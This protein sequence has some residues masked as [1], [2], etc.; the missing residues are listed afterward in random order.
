MY[1]WSIEKSVL[2]LF[3]PFTSKVSNFAP[4]PDFVIWE[5]EN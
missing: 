1:K 5:K 3:L 2:H 4:K